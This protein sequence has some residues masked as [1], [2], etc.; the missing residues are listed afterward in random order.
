MLLK[1]ISKIIR[2][3]FVAGMITIIPIW[4]TVLAIRAIVNLISNTF[5]LLP[6]TLQPK[7]YFPY[8]GVELVIALILIILVGFIANNFFGRRIVKL[9]ETILAKIPI[10]K[11]VYQSVKHLTTGIVSDKKIF[12][13]AVLI[14]FPIKGL[15][16]IG[17]VTGEETQ[18]LP[19]RGQMKM[20][21]VFIPTT[22][23][24]TTGFFCLAPEEEVK[25]LHLSVDE[26]FKM[27]ISV[28][29]SNLKID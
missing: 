11:T 1:K 23:N 16:F 25:P 10:V 19:N 2:N 26:A 21:K 12:S 18:T 6:S 27:I 22:P 28:G 13:R 24:P 3:H 7:T 4:I 15:Y 29:Y 17:F 5:N 9:G 20:L 14:E 8:F